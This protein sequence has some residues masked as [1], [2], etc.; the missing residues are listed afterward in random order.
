MMAAIGIVINL[1]QNCASIAGGRHYKRVLCGVGLA[2]AKGPLITRR[3]FALIG[4]KDS[5]TQKAPG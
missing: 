4:Q 2:A 3:P 5:I 1:E